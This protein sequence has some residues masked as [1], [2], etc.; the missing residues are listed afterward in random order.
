MIMMLLQSIKAFVRK[1]SQALFYCLYSDYMRSERGGGDNM[2][3]ITMTNGS[4]ICW[5][6]D[7]YTDYL[8]DGKIFAVIRGSQWVGI[9]NIDRVQ[10]IRIDK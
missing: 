1:S 4:Y 7:H 9:Y 10:E 2:I 3:Q 8:Y 6:K 5:N